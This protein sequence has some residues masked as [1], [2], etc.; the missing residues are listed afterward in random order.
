MLPAGFTL[1]R[2]TEIPIDGRVLLFTGGVSVMASLLFGL[3]PAIQSSRTDLYDLVKQAAPGVLHGNRSRLRDA[4]VVSEI[5]LALALL[6]GAGLLLQNFVRFQRLDVGFDPSNVLTGR[7][8]LPEYSYS[9]QSQVEAFRED[10]LVAV[11]RES[12]ALEVAVEARLGSRTPFD[13]GFGFEIEGVMPE[14]MEADPPLAAFAISPDY[15]AVKRIRLLR[16]R[17]FTERDRAG[18][19]GVAVV[20]ESL[21]QRMWPDGDAIGRSLRL[22]DVGAGSPWLTVVGITGD[23]RQPA[24]TEMT[25]I[26]FSVYVPIAQHPRAHAD[27]LRAHAQ[28]AGG[29]Y[30]GPA[31][32]ARQSSPSACSAHG[33]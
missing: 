2:I 15:F 11:S 26:P 18:A 25:T 28:R 16:G 5:A 27:V 31:A 32:C 3:A 9:T 4:L 8:H 30:P 24:H 22:S 10:A 7:V 33:G 13:R 12:E 20:N 17:T 14:V 6:V 29:L 19:A 23:V 21:A 1:G